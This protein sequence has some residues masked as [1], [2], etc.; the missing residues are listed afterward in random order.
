MN[1]LEVIAV[2]GWVYLYLVL[3][4]G[5][6]KVVKLIDRRRD[7]ELADVIFWP[8]HLINFAIGL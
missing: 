7:I 3:G 8:I 6:A 5:H 1:N 4:Y 2:L